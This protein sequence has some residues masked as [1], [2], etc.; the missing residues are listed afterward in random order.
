MAI[1]RNQTKLLSPPS[2]VNLTSFAIPNATNIDGSY[3]DPQAVSLIPAN[4]PLSTTDLMKLIQDLVY[5]DE[6][7]NAE[8]GALLPLLNEGVFY[9]RDVKDINQV[10]FYEDLQ[11][12]A[13]TYPADD[14]TLGNGLVKI[15]NTVLSVPTQTTFTVGTNFSLIATPGYYKYAFIEI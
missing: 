14:F 13:V 3:T 12:Q 1:L 9:T 15:Q 2:V 11:L 4:A 7:L 10:S 5:N 6:Q 8:A